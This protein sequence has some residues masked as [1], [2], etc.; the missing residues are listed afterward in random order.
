[1]ASDI[2]VRYARAHP[3]VE[4]TVAVSFFSLGKD[5]VTATAPR[6]L[7]IIDGALEARALREEGYRI[8]G[9]AAG[10]P[11]REDVTYGRFADGT[12][13]R[14]ALADGVEHIGVLYSAESLGEA[15]GWMN[16][17]FGRRGDGF[18]DARGPWL[19]LLYLGVVALAW[20]LAGL[21]PRVAPTPI[22]SGY[23]WRRL[24]PV[25]V[26]PA[27]ATPLVLWKTPTDF[28]PI[29]MGDY[30]TLHF[31]LFGL[32]TAIGIRVVGR[33][34]ETPL[35]LPVSL[36]KFGVAALATTAYSTLAI[37]LPTDA[38]GTPRLRWGSPA[39]RS[40]WRSCAARYLIAS[41]TS[42]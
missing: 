41:P 33:S 35:V 23:G 5:D 12:A 19:A 7:L 4:S 20:A 2:V 17:A 39:C 16:E 32:M 31:A 29:L 38:F 27:L 25:A 28:L 1:M 6:N 30:L 21:L 15:L 9:L 14:L 11:A 3:D 37:G 24:L 18:V 34:R 10:G 22:G 8:V 13:R 42:G 26:V 36:P 40:F